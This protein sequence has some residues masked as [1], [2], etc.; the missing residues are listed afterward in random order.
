MHFIIE[1]ISM[2]LLKSSEK[3]KKSVLLKSSEK[4]ARCVSSKY[5]IVGWAVYHNFWQRKKDQLYL[6]F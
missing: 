1:R 2:V 4:V 5:R 6:A 3:R